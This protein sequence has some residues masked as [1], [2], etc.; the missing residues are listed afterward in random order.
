MRVD[1]SRHLVWLTRGRDWGFRFLSLG[2]FSLE[3]AQKAYQVVFGE[4][5][6][7]DR[8]VVGWTMKCG[9][10]VYQFV[11]YRFNDC[12]QSWK[13]IAGRVIPHEMIVVNEGDGIQC[14]R[15]ELMDCVRPFYAQQF[16]KKNEDVLRLSNCPFELRTVSSAEANDKHIITL[17]EPYGQGEEKHRFGWRYVCWGLILALLGYIVVAFSHRGEPTNGAVVRHAN[18]V[19]C[20]GHPC[21]VG[22]ETNQVTRQRLSGEFNKSNT[23]EKVSKDGAGVNAN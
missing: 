20:S 19:R 7:G 13:D 11:A 16:L 15:D 12:R 6:Y 10:H 14:S 4:N 2:P 18:M 3:L 8:E 17:R 1:L 9:E 22:P 23:I 5:G 21:V